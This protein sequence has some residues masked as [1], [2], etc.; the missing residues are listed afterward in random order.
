MDPEL[1]SEGVGGM[2]DP[3]G[4]VGELARGANV[5]PGGGPAQQGGGTQYGRPPEDLGGPGAE[6]LPGV[7]GMEVEGLEG[8]PGLDGMGGMPGMEGL[9]GMGHPESKV[10]KQWVCLTRMRFCVEF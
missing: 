7:P 5:Y 2:N 9:P 4:M 8:I 3:R 1:M 6:P 10:C